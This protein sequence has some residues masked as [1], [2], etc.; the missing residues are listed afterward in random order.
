MDTLQEN[1]RDFM[2]AFAGL[3]VATIWPKS[4][5]ALGLGRLQRAAAGQ[6]KSAGPGVRFA[7]LYLNHSHIYGSFSQ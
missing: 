4:A 7:A 2:K 3:A 1:R 5:P 6:R